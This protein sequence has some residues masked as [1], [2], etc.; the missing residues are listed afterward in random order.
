[1]RKKAKIWLGEL[2]MSIAVM[3]QYSW[4]R[5]CR[6][7]KT[8]PLSGYILAPS[9]RQSTLWCHH[10]M[11]LGRIVRRIAGFWSSM[12]DQNTA[13]RKHTQ[14]LIGYQYSYIW[15]GPDPC[16]ISVPKSVPGIRPRRIVCF[17]APDPSVCSSYGFPHFESVRSRSA[18]VP[19]C[20]LTWASSSA[21]PIRKMG[22]S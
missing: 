15:E 18:H 19:M 3:P 6:I 13:T 10:R 8:D 9:A 20:P 2:D 4:R 21:Q 22:N 12:N 1:M 14:C 16:G 7:S 11:M 17:I 5:P